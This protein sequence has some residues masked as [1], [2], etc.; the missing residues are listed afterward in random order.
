MKPAAV[1]TDPPS[2]DV[3]FPEG[4][5]HTYE[6]RITFHVKNLGEDQRKGLRTVIFILRLLES[7]V[8]AAGSIRKAA[9]EMGVSKTFLHAVLR[10]QKPPGVKLAKAVGYLPK[11]LYMRDVQAMSGRGWQPW[12]EDQRGD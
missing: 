3:L 12:P 10:G 7:R 1:P 11:V 5:T 8:R 2:E 6:P 4:P 9:A